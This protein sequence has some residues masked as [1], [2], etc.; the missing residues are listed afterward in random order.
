MPTKAYN[1]LIE[2]LEDQAALID[3]Y[4]KDL[5]AQALRHPRDEELQRQIAAEIAYQI[6][7]LARVHRDRDSIRAEL[8]N[9]K[10]G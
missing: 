2:A 6:K 4:L 9:M 5:Q 10:K 3:R 1:R 7:E 8:N